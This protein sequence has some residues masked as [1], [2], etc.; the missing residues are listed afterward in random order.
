MWIYI[1]IYTHHIQNDIKVGGKLELEIEEQPGMTSK[2]CHPKPETSPLTPKPPKMCQQILHQIFSKPETVPDTFRE[3]NDKCACI[4]VS[5]QICIYYTC[6][7]VSS[8]HA[9]HVKDI[10]RYMMLLVPL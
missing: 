4:Y 6:N 7:Y 3:I 8:F 10:E 2:T 5:N 9:M 1:Y